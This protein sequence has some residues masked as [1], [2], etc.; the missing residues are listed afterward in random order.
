M[1]SHWLRE[2]PPAARFVFQG[3]AAAKS[4]AG[5]LWNV[6][7]PES[8]CRAVAHGGR[9]ALWLGPDEFLL[10]DAER[11]NADT[12]TEFLKL[13]RDHACSVVDVS[14]R[15]MGW[16]ITGAFAET[17]LSGACPLDLDVD[18]FPV[19]MCTRTVLAKAE[20]VLWRREAEI[21]HLETWRSFAPY[22]TA[23]LS[24]IASGYQLP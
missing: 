7:L 13:Q 20:I 17:I 12:S 1:S 18:H 19:G 11:S 3:G 21:F 2:L 8:A 15:Q 16:E 5:T 14:H 4:A 24:E 22:V 6:P 9:A 23:L 10:W